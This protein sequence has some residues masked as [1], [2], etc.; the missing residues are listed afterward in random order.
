[1]DDSILSS[2]LTPTIL[3]IRSSAER[4]TLC[5]PDTR[6]IDTERFPELE[7]DFDALDTNPAPAEESFPAT[8]TM[9]ALSKT[10]A[11][12]S[13]DEYTV[14]WLC[15]LDY[16]YDVATA[17]LDE[18]HDTPFKPHDDPSSYTVG[19][20]GGHSVV[21]AKC[22]RTGTANASTAV[23]HMLR[24]FDKIRFGL[25]V[26]IGGGAADAPGSHD[27]RRST[28]DILLGD[29]VVSK[30][31]GNH[32]GIL[33]YDKGRRGPEKF[34]IESHL[35]SPGDLLISATD[36][37]SRDHRFKRGNMAGYIEEA[38]LKLEAL[39][40][41]HFS[42]P[43]RHHDL[44][45]AT[46]YNHPNETENDCRNCDSAEVV[47]TSVPRNDPVVHYG[48]IAS[49]NTVVRD[50][51][52]RDTMRREHNVVCFDM[53][54]AGLMNNFPCLV[55]RGISDYADTHK[56]DLWQPYAAL[57]A[58]AYA[59]DLL[60]LIQPQEIVAL[61]KYIGPMG[62]V[63]S[64]DV[65]EKQ[66]YLCT[67]IVHHL[68]LDRPLSPV[69]Y[70]SLSDHEDSQ[71]LQ[72]RV[73]LLG[74]MVKQLLLFNTTPENPCKIPTTLRNAYESHCRSETI[75][76]Q[77]FEA[78]LDEHKR[79]YLVIDGLDLCSEDALTILKAY[80]LELISQGCR[81]SL[82]T[83]AFSDRQAVMEI[84]CN[85]CNRE[86]LNVFFNCA[87]KGNDFDLC[88]HCKEAGITCPHSHEGDVT[89]D[90]IRV[91][92]RAR[93]GEIELLCRHKL[94]QAKDAGFRR[95][96]AR[97][98]PHSLVD[99]LRRNPK[100]II[101]RIARKIERQAQGNFFVAQAWIQELLGRD[102]VPKDAE[103]LLADLNFM[104]L[105]RLEPYVT[106]KINGIRRS[107]TDREVK[108]AFDTFMVMITAH[109][110]LTV[111]A[112][113]HALALGSDL[114]AIRK[115]NLDDRLSILKATNGL[116]TIEKADA[117]NAYVHF[118]H[119]TLPSILA[120]SVQDT[121]GT[122]NSKMASLCLTY[123]KDPDFVK[124]STDPVAYPF[125]SYVLRH[126]G[127]H[128]RSACLEFDQRIENEA[129]E[130]LGNPDN[131]RMIVG[132]AAGLKACKVPLT[133]IHEGID[134]L[135]LCAWFGL[136]NI[137]RR[138]RE[139][140]GYDVNVVDT[141]HCRT[142]LRYAC[143]RGH[144]D[145][146]EQLALKVP[147]QNEDII[148]AISGIPGTQ[149]SYR[150]LDDRKSI[151]EKLLR[152]QNLTLNSVLDFTNT[153][154]TLLMYAVRLE[155]YE[156]VERLLWEQSVD[157]NV[158]NAEGHTALWL[159]VYP[160][161]SRLA[162]PRPRQ[163]NMMRMLLRRGA[164][165]N[166]KYETGD[167]VLSYAVATGQTH[168]AAALLECDDLNLH[169]EKNLIHIASANNHPGIIPPLHSALLKR[170]IADI[171]ARDE[172]GLTP[173]HY[174]ALSTSKRA[175]TT[176]RA[177]L[178]LGAN[179]DIPDDRGCTPF[180]IAS[181]LCR[182]ET[183]KVL[184][185]APALENHSLDPKPEP[186]TATK[187]LKDLP[188]LT[189]ARHGHW[190]LLQDL[191]TA[192]IGRRPDLAYRDIATGETLLHLATRANQIGILR[193]L[194]VSAPA[195]A[196]SS[197]GSSRSSGGIRELIC[198]GDGKG[199]TPLRLA[200]KH[201]DLV[202][203]LLEYHNRGCACGI[204]DAG[205]DAD[206]VA[207]IDANGGTGPSPALNDGESDSD[208]LEKRCL[209]GAGVSPSLG[210]SKQSGV[211]NFV[212][213]SYKDLLFFRF[214]ATKPAATLASDL[215][216]KLALGQRDPTI[217]FQLLG[218][219]ILDEEDPVRV[220]RKMLGTDVACQWQPVK[221]MAPTLPECTR[222]IRNCSVRSFSRSC[223]M[224][225]HKSDYALMCYVIQDTADPYLAT[226]DAFPE[227]ELSPSNPDPV[228]LPWLEAER[229]GGNARS[230]E[231]NDFEDRMEA[232][233]LNRDDVIMVNRH[234]RSQT[235]KD[236]M[237]YYC[238]GS[239][240]GFGRYF[241][242]ERLD[243]STTREAASFGSKGVAAALDGFDKLW[244]DTTE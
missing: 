116:I 126:W 132:N 193:L 135:H 88:L 230:Q 183:M 5:F 209:G 87:C 31:E 232:G 80:P 48:L 202:E 38:Q 171:N 42:F 6:T 189:L 231:R 229:H 27:P 177:L 71:K 180:T 73:N 25:M 10:R 176:A 82:L 106:G 70:I 188:A 13:C 226:M 30:P 129:L 184:A 45:F 222:D 18:E 175:P 90:T 137:I 219:L 142:T 165:P 210:F 72:T 101:D 9:T 52:M 84:S 223:E 148:A 67:L 217:H 190:S 169:T 133:W 198:C 206:A 91:E 211:H 19:R 138:L 7:V 112:L 164:D 47:R 192:S 195:P 144:A 154:R 11:K 37:L 178:D 140:V 94:D 24:T 26:G 100:E 216:E 56:N 64:F 234:V 28:T 220:C 29:V 174:A 215:R 120:A 63:V 203:L 208:S 99:F 49:G 166:L 83:T 244:R 207:D 113:Q 227:R 8:V 181:L 117:E 12:L 75:L 41:S 158:R 4:G 145:T 157:V 58:A 238:V 197:S 179:P 199:V 235:E 36:K 95:Y 21:I 182:T 141:K 237:S 66:S 127:D 149:P 196:S 55:I 16:E 146:V 124:H 89:N 92:V 163:A 68:R 102:S 118:F 194:L 111:L 107:K 186:S 104:P 69:I 170:D 23:T 162:P 44:L 78:L 1:M 65:M 57:T 218:I 125:S 15:V 93:P 122:A 153:T 85:A 205:A 123:L 160:A 59:K 77:S 98:Y 224:P 236:F 119:A 17:L 32:G 108:L 161:S 62:L 152:K 2:G 187:T 53:E 76:K 156:F 212:D 201:P 233:G 81:L 35:N 136:S 240:V 39:G 86:R 168:A 51:H 128:V 121:L 110:P 239:L 191:I 34:E 22:T 139:D 131:V 20:I 173:L 105:T 50:A 103:R 130:F 159:T 172:N 214:R 150:E 43:G 61:D 213:L 14:G 155:N 33:Q 79:T 221:A 151:V 114:G 40:M 60:A 228:S 3:H 46:R 147:V 200:R 243:I 241:H 242:Y 96:D 115:G 204:N 225:W 109:Q 185:P 167:T 134:A 54:A 97:E 74:S 143:A